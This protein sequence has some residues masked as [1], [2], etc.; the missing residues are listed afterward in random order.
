MS[1]RIA[2]TSLVAH[3]NGRA[4]ILVRAPFQGASTMTG[5]PR[6]KAW[7][8]PWAILFSHFVATD[9]FAHSPIRRF[10]HTPF[11]VD[12]AGNSPTVHQ[13]YNDNVF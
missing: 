9:P 6:A 4:R 2:F 13:F 10:A 1:A 8:K 12:L 7:L 3:G 11:R 5:V